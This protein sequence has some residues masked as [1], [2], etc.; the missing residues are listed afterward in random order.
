MLELGARSHILHADDAEIARK[1]SIE[2]RYPHANVLGEALGYH[3]TRY[4]SVSKI[5]FAQ[6][7]IGGVDRSGKHPT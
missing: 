1:R 7:G 5:V 6:Y 2:L 4:A 3:A